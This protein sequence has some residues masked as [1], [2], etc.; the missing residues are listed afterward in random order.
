MT[1]TSSITTASGKAIARPRM[2]M[3]PIKF[4]N[5]LDRDFHRDI[6]Q[7]VARYFDTNGFGKYANRMVVFKA[8]LFLTLTVGAYTLIL[9]SGMGPWAL[10]GLANLFGAS[11]LLLAI[12]VAHD[13]AHHALTPFSPGEPCDPDSGLHAAWCKRLSVA[14][15][16]R[17]IA[18]QFPQRQWLRCRY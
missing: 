7:R 3:R 9:T 16:A 5:E 17:Q 12:N 18:P 15:A 10:L 14:I 11:S 13:A 6:R 1:D 8:A 4:R 2:R